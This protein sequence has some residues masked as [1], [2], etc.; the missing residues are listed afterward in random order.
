MPADTARPLHA[1]MGFAGDPAEGA[2]LVFAPDWR[3][4]KR[5]AYVGLLGLFAVDYLDVRCRRLREHGDYLRSLGD[6]ARLAAGVAHVIDDPAGCPGCNTWGIPP[7]EDG[8][9]CQHCAQESDPE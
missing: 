9:H 3:E 1:W 8:L 6:A 2:V 7:T 5:L 4:A